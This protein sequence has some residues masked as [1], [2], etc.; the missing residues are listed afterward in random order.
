MGLTTPPFGDPNRRHAQRIEKV[1]VVQSQCHHALRRGRN[2][3]FAMDMAHG[4][5]E[6]PGQSRRGD[7]ADQQGYNAD[8]ERHGNLRIRGWARSRGE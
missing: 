6:I 7:E 8:E 1:L 4:D 5:R 3:G 2:S